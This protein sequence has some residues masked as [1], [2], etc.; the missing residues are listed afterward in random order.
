MGVSVTCP[1]CS[2]RYL[3]KEE[4]AGKRF[5][6][7]GC[8]SSLTIPL[9]QASDEADVLPDFDALVSAGEAAPATGA[10][11]FTAAA[12]PASVE[13]ATA[14]AASLGGPRPPSRG[15]SLSAI[16][17]WAY[18]GAAV[19]VALAV[20]YFVQTASSALAILF[21]LAAC[22]GAVTGYGIVLAA[23]LRARPMV[24]L[25][26]V[27]RPYSL[28][29]IPAVH[30][31]TNWRQLRLARVLFLW[32]IVSFIV[33]TVWLGR[34]ER[35]RDESRR[36]DARALAERSRAVRD[37]D[38]Q[39]SAFAHSNSATAHSRGPIDPADAN[40]QA[41]EA[42]QRV[43]AALTA[44]AASHD[45]SYPH[46]L[47]ELIGTGGIQSSDLNSRACTITYHFLPAGPSRKA[48]K[49][50]QVVAFDA[51]SSGGHRAVLFGDGHIETIDIARWGEFM[52]R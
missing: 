16:P 22:G 23:A 10:R 50:D 49:P 8:G 44:Y 39:T 41:A 27:L 1:G 20:C 9:P 34:A 7:K 43:G 17:L 25:R 6:C 28:L 11:P 19:A 29:V 51:R 2:K 32:S 38:S 5:R 37:L 15:W 30:L 12:A 24:F 33:G 40:M 18:A 21:L 3:V 13:T 14:A 45:G 35:L 36:A 46:S 42:L 4:S 52:S 48:P 31:A 47:V 26:F